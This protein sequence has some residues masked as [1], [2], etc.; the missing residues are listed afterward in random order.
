M[1]AHLSVTI[2]DRVNAHHFITYSL[3][4]VRTG[5][6][7]TLLRRRKITWEKVHRERNKMPGSIKVQAQLLYFEAYFAMWKLNMKACF[8]IIETHGTVKSGDGAKRL[9]Y[10]D[11]HK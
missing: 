4:M 1:Y 6:L 2:R 8:M 3:H 11:N 7:A 5:S 10:Q 9:H